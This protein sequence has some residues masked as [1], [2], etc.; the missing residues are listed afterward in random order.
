MISW[1]SFQTQP[2]RVI[3]L[4]VTLTWKQPS[5]LLQY[6]ASHET[7]LQLRSK[8][9][10]S[11]ITSTSFVQLWKMWRRPGKREISNGQ[12]KFHELTVS[13]G[14]VPYITT[15]LCLTGGF[16]VNII[17]SSH[18]ICQLPSQLHAFFSLFSNSI[19]PGS[20]YPSI[21]RNVCNKS[22]IFGY[23][24]LQICPQ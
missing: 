11:S 3:Q 7:Y 14:A 12:T 23:T 22:C 4:M 9:S 17:C 5:R 18:S 10:P 20:S 13:L 8:K 2:A 21:Q 6:R 19:S 15:A 16:A 24:A 1:F